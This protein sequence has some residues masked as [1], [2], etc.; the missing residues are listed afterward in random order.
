[1]GL[2][3]F[4]ENRLEEF[5]QANPHLELLAL[6]EQINEQKQDTLKLINQLE[7]T[8]KRLQDEIL[9]VAQDIQ[10]WHSR[11]SK[12]KAAGRMDLADAAQERE[13]ALLRQGNQLWGQMEAAKQQIIQSQ[14]LLVKIEAKQKEIKLKKQEVQKTQYTQQSTH[15]TTGWNQ[16]SNYRNS[17]SAYD[18]LDAKFQK[19]EM[20]EEI[21]KMKRQMGK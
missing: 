7:L 10:N 5:L 21:E 19:W 15:D 11:V 18:D 12:A 3:D 16:G 2:F 14:E 8:Q 17:T 13:A 9:S 6:E 1:M 20:D 4:L